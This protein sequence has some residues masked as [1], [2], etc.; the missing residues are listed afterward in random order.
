MAWSM[1][2]PMYNVSPRIR[3]GYHALAGAVVAGLREQGFDEP[4]ALADDVALPDFWR[5]PDMLLSQTCGYPYLHLLRGQVSLIAT[6]AYDFAGCEG[7]NYASAI[8]ARAGGGIAT[9]P[10]ARGR[11]AAANDRCSNSG[12]NALRHAVAPLA[13]EGRFFSAVLWS[14]S[15]RASLRMVQRGDA[16]IAAIDCV[17][18]GYLRREEPS[19]LDGLTLLGFTA[20]S[21]GLPFI[22]GA[23]VPPALRA[24]LQHALLTPSP[25]LAGTL[26]AL[27][28]LR[29]DARGDDDYQLIAAMEQEARGAG[30][31][32]LG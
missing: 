31:R 14:G 28:L 10:D 21:P 27:S 30:Y 7:S 11:I 18:L 20:S 1:A 19:S 17:T 4:V 24:A 15:H 3:D 25:A 9:L 6:P 23:A 29:F 5:R 13:R 8:M 16:D 12:M 22:A 32:L 2:F 26:P